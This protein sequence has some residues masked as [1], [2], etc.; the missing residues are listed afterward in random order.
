MIAPRAFGHADDISSNLYAGSLCRLRP[1]LVKACLP[2]KYSGLEVARIK[3]I[4]STRNRQT[5]ASPPVDMAMLAAGY[6]AWAPHYDADMRRYGYRVPAL[7]ADQLR[8]HVSN[9]CALVLD[10]GAGSGLVGKALKAL[11]YQNVVGLDPSMAMLRQAWAQGV[12]RRCLK[13]ALGAPKALA[14]HRFDAIL[15]AGVF[16]AGHAPPETLAD[17]VSAARP[18]GIIIFNLQCDK[19]LAAD[20]HRMRLRLEMHHQWRP[21]ITT[22]PFDPLPGVAVEQNNVIYVYQTVGTAAGDTAPTLIA[23]RGNRTHGLCNR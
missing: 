21:L 23:D 2:L 10:V 7:M 17:L 14:D 18:E 6:D 13:M 20:Y 19:V 1:L 11:G 3:P 15:A 16:K 5:A 8:R 22:V 12:Y 9:R 4:P